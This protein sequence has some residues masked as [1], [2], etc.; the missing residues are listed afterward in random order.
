MKLNFWEL[1]VI[2]FFCCVTSGSNVVGRSGRSNVIKL[3]SSNIS[4]VQEGEWF[5]KF[6]VDWC[7]ACQRMGPIW[8]EFSSEVQK[9]TE[10]R[11]RIK[12]AEINV[13]EDRGI[14]IRFLLDSYPTI[15]YIRQGHIYELDMSNV[16]EFMNYLENQE[17]YH[18][19]EKTYSFGYSPFSI[20]GQ[21]F[22]GVFGFIIDIVFNVDEIGR[23]YQNQYH[24]SDKTL[25]VFYALALLILVITIIFITVVVLLFMDSLCGHF[26]FGVPPPRIPKEEKQKT[27]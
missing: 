24:F 23:Q 7:G 13:D 9:R 4:L 6:Y 17:V 11:N 15:F 20:I 26:I 25:Y 16:H 22:G 18:L 12:V 14:L 10:F 8:S 19:S 2:L 3:D 5:I 21:I 27:D 1:I